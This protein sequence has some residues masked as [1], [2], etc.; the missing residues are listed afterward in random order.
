MHEITVCYSMP[1]RSQVRNRISYVDG[2]PGHYGIGHKIETTGLVG[3]IFGLVSPNVALIGKEEKLS[4]CMQGLPLVQLCVDASPIVRTLQIAKDEEGLHQATIF[5]QGARESILTRIRLHATDEQRRGD[6][7]SFEGACH[8]EQI[9]PGTGDQVLID[10]PFEQGL[11]MLVGLRPIHA[12]EPLLTEIANTWRELEP[13]Q[14][15]E[16]KHDFG[17]P[18]SVCRMFDDRQ[19]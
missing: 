5:L 16:G 8:P 1:L 2:V 6:P 11:D 3:L 7:A 18:S 13:Q 10:R 15:E 17:K 19:L 9:I 14:I 4:E 12:V